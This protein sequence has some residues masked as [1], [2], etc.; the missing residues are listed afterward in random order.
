MD[1]EQKRQLVAKV[2]ELVGSTGIEALTQFVAS[3]VNRELFATL[4]RDFVSQQK[5][6][7]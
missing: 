6:G 5:S 1:D 7:G 4:I 3:Q 2:Q